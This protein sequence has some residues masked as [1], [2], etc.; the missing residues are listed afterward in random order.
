MADSDEENDAILGDNEDNDEKRTQKIKKNKKKHQS[1]IAEDDGN[2]I[3]DF[4]DP[5]AAQNVTSTMPK[6]KS[7]ELDDQHS[8]SRNGGFKI[9][10]DGRLIIEDDSDSE[11]EQHKKKLH[12][13]ESDGSDDEGKNGKLNSFAYPWQNNIYPN[14]AQTYNQKYKMLLYFRYF[15][16]YV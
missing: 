3:V 6:P 7:S 9:A 2:D 10:K 4:L 1:Y 8:K 12:F 16:E 15:K 11:E 5:S 13:M 14:Y